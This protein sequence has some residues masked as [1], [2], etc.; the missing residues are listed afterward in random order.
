MA[1]SS[2]SF[3]NEVFSKFAFYSAVVLLK[4]VVM[5]MW[6]ARYRI[7][8]NV[9]ALFFLYIIEPRHEKTC[10]RDFR[11]AETQTGLLSYRD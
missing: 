8:R 1:A 9:S 11:Q 2:L 6:T 3:E 5:S 10:L 7:P 4:T